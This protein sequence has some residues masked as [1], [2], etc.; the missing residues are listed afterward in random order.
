MNAC[1]VTYARDESGWWVASIREVRG[2]HTQGRTVDEARRRIREALALFVDDAASAKLID[3]VKLPATAVKAI[4]AYATLRKRAD[5]EDRR[6]ALAARRAVRLLRGG[7]LKMSAR[8][9]ARLLGVSHQ[10]VHQL[11]HDEG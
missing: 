11:A 7:K 8:D 10:R 6:A 4:R 5:Q 2:C 9:A 3:N 1:H